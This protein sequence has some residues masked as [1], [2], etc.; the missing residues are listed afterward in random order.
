MIT[1]RITR[2]DGSKWLWN[3]LDFAYQWTWITSRVMEEFGCDYAEIAIL[4]TEDQGDVL[5]VRGER[6]GLMGI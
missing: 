1:V 5:T 3:Y 2:M 4:E 6:V